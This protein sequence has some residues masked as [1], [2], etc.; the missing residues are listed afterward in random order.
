VDAFEQFVR[1]GLAQAGI[2]IEDFELEIMRFADQLYGPE[3]RA[4]MEADLAGVWAEKDL[5]PSRPP[6]S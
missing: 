4:L 5:D 6:T 2:E 3:L 1:G